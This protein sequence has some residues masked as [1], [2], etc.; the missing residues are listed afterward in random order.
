MEI[1]LVTMGAQICLRDLSKIVSEGL[2]SGYTQCFFK[3]LLPLEAGG[4]D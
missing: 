1:I 3:A 2:D 4:T